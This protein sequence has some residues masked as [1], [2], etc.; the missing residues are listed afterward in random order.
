MERFL[1]GDSGDQVDLL[2]VDESFVLVCVVFLANRDSRQRASALTEELDNGAGIDTSD[3]RN[4]LP[5]APFSKRLNGSPVRVPGGIV[6]ND[7]SGSLNVWRLKVLQ[8]AVLVALGR[9]D[10]V[11]SNQRLSKDENLSAVGRI[12]HGLWVSDEGG[13]KDSFA[14]DVGQGAK[15]L[16]MKDG[17][18]LDNVSK[19]AD[20]N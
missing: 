10:T 5:G 14:R 2:G 7:D 20:P 8:E 4:T 19:Q 9:W 17:S 13:C 12:G 1:G 18:V 11:V 3:G 16:A 15:G 6:R